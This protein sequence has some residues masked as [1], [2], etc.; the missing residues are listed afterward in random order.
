MLTEGAFFG[1]RALLKNQVRQRGHRRP[2][3]AA[4]YR[5]HH[6]G[7]ALSARSSRRS[8]APRAGHVPPSMSPELM[9]QLRGVE[10]LKLRS[11]KEQI[12]ASSPIGA[13]R[14]SLGWAT[15]LCGRAS[16]ATASLSSRA[17][18]PTA[19][20]GA[21]R[22][23]RRVRP[24]RR[25]DRVRRRRRQGQ[26]REGR[27]GGRREG[28]RRGWRGG[29]GRRRYEMQP[30]EEEPLPDPPQLILPKVIAG[31]LGRPRRQ[32]REP[33]DVAGV[34]RARAASE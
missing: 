34:W 17:A 20:G 22:G 21:R 7:R 3:G 30:I 28:G 33:C 14:S 25:A 2:I 5:L 10:L 18:P 31:A 12:K 19:S 29:G 24:A 1:E 13:P 6:E 27:Q 11:K 26:G 23:A 4:P 9:Q 8:S 16:R 15:T 32:A